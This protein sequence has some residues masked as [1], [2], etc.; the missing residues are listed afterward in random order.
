MEAIIS[1]IEIKGEKYSHEGKG[2]CKKLS[3]IPLIKYDETVDESVGFLNY[4]LS[5]DGE[6]KERLGVWEYKNGQ[7]KGHLY[8]MSEG[9]KIDKGYP[10]TIYYCEY[11]GCGNQEITA[12]EHEDN[13]GSCNACLWDALQDLDY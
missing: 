8:E 9:F 2:G 6:K 4:W 11:K 10:M 3:D 7:Y 12:Q 1:V 13:R 5:S